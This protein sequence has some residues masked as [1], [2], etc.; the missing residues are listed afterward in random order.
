MPTR[1]ALTSPLLLALTSCAATAHHPTVTGRFTVAEDFDVETEPSGSSSQGNIEYDSAEFGLGLTHIQGKLNGVR[2]RL[3]RTQVAFASSEYGNVGAFDLIAGG[4]WMPL[5][6]GALEPF[7]SV[8][9]VAT[10][11]D[12]FQGAD[13]GEQFALR[14]GI[15]LDYEI[16]ELAFFDITLDWTVPVSGADADPIGG[17]PRSS[18]LGGLALRVGAGL[19][20]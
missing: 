13:L 18:E 6:T 5:T 17:Q 9:G 15:G 12:D 16:N 14:L 7:L 11:L 3:A 10:L 20:F 2:D 8:D 4:R 1:R 19:S